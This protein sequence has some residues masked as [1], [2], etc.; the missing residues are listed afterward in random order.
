MIS[1]I[2]QGPLPVLI[3]LILLLA[4]T[5]GFFPRHHS[6][7]LQGRKPAPLKS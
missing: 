3:T 2:C 4:V 1:K 7:T 6:T 5:G